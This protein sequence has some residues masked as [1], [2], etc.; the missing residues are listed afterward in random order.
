MSLRDG[1]LQDWPYS[2]GSFM[3]PDMV[4][5]AYLWENKQ[6]HLL[7]IQIKH[8]AKRIHEQRLEIKRLAKTK[9]L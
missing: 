2:A 3:T 7:E 8:L 1:P 9:E 6:R 4:W 5:S